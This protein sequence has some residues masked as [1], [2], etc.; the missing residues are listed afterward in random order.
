V[1]SGVLTNGDVYTV[2]FPEP[3][4]FKLVCL[5]HSMMTATVHVMDPVETLPHDQSY[6]QHSRRADSIG[7]IGGVSLET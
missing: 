5:V 2:T 7:C 6:Y 1:N 4:N 3:G